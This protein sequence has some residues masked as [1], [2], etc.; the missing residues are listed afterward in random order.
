MGLSTALIYFPVWIA[1]FANSTGRYVAQFDPLAKRVASITDEETPIPPGDTITSTETA[2]IQIIPH[3]CPN[4]GMDLPDNARSTTYY[5]GNCR[6]MFFDRGEG[7]RRLQVM[8]PAGLD[9]QSTLF[10][11]WVFDLLSSDWPGKQN[12]LKDL[13]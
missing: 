9:A 3:R 1:R 8:I 13:T 4:C 2:A 7:Y 6:R 10:P 11:F 5:C 12:L